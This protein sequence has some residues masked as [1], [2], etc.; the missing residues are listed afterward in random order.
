MQH[1]PDPSRVPVGDEHTGGPRALDDLLS[2][3][4][5][6]EVDHHDVGV[7][8]DHEHA[9][10]INECVGEPPR[11]RV[12]LVHP[13]QV[14]VEPVQR[15]RAEDPRLS[16]ATAEPLPHLPRAPHRLR[17]A[18]EAGAHRRA[19]PFRER[20]HHRRRARREVGKRGP[21]GDVGV[22]EARTVQVHGESGFRRSGLDGPQVGERRDHATGAVVRV[23]HAHDGRPR[24]MHRVGPVR[25]AQRLGLHH[26]PAAHQPHL[27]S[28]ECRRPRDLPVHDVRV[29]VAEHLSTGLAEQPER[30]LIRH[31]PRREEERLR[32]AEHRRDPGFEPLDRGVAVE[33][34]IT[35][36]G[37]GH[38]AAHRRR[39]LCDGVA[40]EIDR[41]GHG[42]G[43]GSVGN[44][45]SR[46]AEARACAVV[47]NSAVFGVRGARSPR[48]TSRIS[49]ICATSA[50]ITNISAA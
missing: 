34:V 42:S 1:A 8:G 39:G 37:L 10:H 45:R 31:C 44:E 14:Y 4:P 35:H 15:R 32:L 25:R 17:V 41:R 2:G 3:L 46:C 50:P 38:R 47:A 24:C 6:D 36:L 13:R 30:G 29:V 40:A 23:L 48:A 5:G 19:K 21:R 16:H 22:P 27:K 11:E 20:H 49:T 18:S 33:D 7:G 26:R 12:I 43:V 28:R 9:R